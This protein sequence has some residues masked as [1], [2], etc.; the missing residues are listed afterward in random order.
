MITENTSL[1]GVFGGTEYDL[2]KLFEGYGP[3]DADLARAKRIAKY[4]IKYGKLFT[5]RADLA[6]SQMVH[7]TGWLRYTGVAKP[8]WNNFAGNGV[9]GPANVGNRFKTE[10]LGVI[11]QFA[12]LAWYVTPK[13]VN[14]YCSQKY[15]PRHFGNTHRY[16]GDTTLKRLEGHWAVPGKKYADRIADYA[17]LI[18]PSENQQSTKERIIEKVS[19]LFASKDILQVDVDE[20]INIITKYNWQYIAIHHTVSGQ[21]WTTMDKI[22]Q[23]HLAR[24]P[25]FLRE[26][27]NFGVNGNGEIEIGRPLNMQGAHVKYYNRVAIGIA[28]YG[29]FRTDKMTSK[30]KTSVFELAAE[31]QRIKKID[32]SKFLGHGEFP[33]QHTSC[34][35]LDMDKFRSDYLNWLQKK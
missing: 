20:A 29:D 33:R 19:G 15:D 34:P 7:E 31:L 9:T 13:H 23:W 10:E 12:H 35:C 11:A 18:F 21:F 1:I 24:K 28:I 2:Y 27:Y 17:N 16:N 3:K 8:E 25:P 6:W 30:Q 14:G 26:G 22:K 5:I 4:Y 32:T